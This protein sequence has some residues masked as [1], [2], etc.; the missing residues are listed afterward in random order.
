[1]ESFGQYLKAAREAKKISLHAISRVTRIRRAILEDIERDQRGFLLPEVVVKNFIEAYAT[2]IGLDPEE[3]LSRYA[4]WQKRGAAAA[5]EES[6][7]DGKR[8]IFTRYI[9]AGAGATCLIVVVICSFLFF[10]GHPREGGQ[11]VALAKGAPRHKKMVSSQGLPS[12]PAPLLVT[13]NASL[14]SPPVDAPQDEQEK[15]ALVREHLLVIKASE[16]TWIQIQDGPSLPFDVILSRGESYARKSTHPLAIVIGN[17]GTVT[18]TF[19]GK[20]LGVLGRGGEVI[21]LTL[22]SLKE[23]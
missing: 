4:K 5:P 20:D 17:A 8:E 12:S 22:P 16:R 13:Q 11:E 23:G 6:P 15:S 7:P 9:F 1:M 19:D 14:S 21:K 2:Y 3:A 18:V 10:P